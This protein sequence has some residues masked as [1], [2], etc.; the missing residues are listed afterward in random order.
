[1]E[2]D[3]LFGEYPDSNDPN[4]TCL[5]SADY[6]FYEL[7]E[8][9]QPE[10]PISSKKQWYNR[11]LL[12]QRM[13]L[14]QDVSLNISE[15]GTGK[16]GCFI[17]LSEYIKDNVPQFKQCIVLSP[18]T[19]GKQF[20]NDL[21]F[22]YTNGRYI[23][24]AIR[25]AKDKGGRNTAITSSI[26]KFYTKFTTFDDFCRKSYEKY[27]DNVASL[28]TK[29]SDTLFCC[30]EIHLFKVDNQSPFES[31]RVQNY[32]QL[33][34][35]FHVIQRSKV[36]YFTATP[37]TRVTNEYNY[38][39]NLMY[40]LDNQ[41]DTPL[42]RKIVAQTGLD[43]D[44][45]EE[46]NWGY[47]SG[48]DY[49]AYFYEHLRGKVFFAASSYDTAPYSYHVVLT[50]EP[51]VPLAVQQFFR[52]IQDASTSHVDY[53]AIDRTRR[54]NML[55]GG[56]QQITYSR[57]VGTQTFEELGIAD[58]EG[59]T[60]DG[61]QTVARSLSSFVFPDGSHGSA[62]TNAWT[63]EQNGHRIVNNAVTWPDSNG[64]AQNL[65]WWIYNHLAA[66]SCKFYYVI[67][68]ALFLSGKS[69]VAI[70]NVNAGGAAI[71][72]LTLETF[73]FVRYDHGSAPDKRLRYSV[74]EGKTGSKTTDIFSIFN[75]PDN[76]HG[77]YIKV[78]IMSRVAQTGISLLED[79]R[80]IVADIPWAP[81]QLY[82]T[83]KRA[84]RVGAHKY[85]Q[86]E[87]P[88]FTVE[89]SIL[90][91]ET[92]YSPSVDLNIYLRGDDT[93]RVLAEPLRGLKQI[94]VDCLLE[95]ARNNLPASLNGYPEADYGAASY[96]CYYC[97]EVQALNYKTYNT[98]YHNEVLQ[99]YQHA[100]IDTF[101]AN[102]VQTVDTIADL[103]P[104][105][106]QKIYVEQVLLDLVTRGAV[107]EDA[108]GLPSVLIMTRPGVFQLTRLTS[109]RQSHDLILT[110]SS[111]PIYTVQYD[112]DITDIIIAN[113]FLHVYDNFV[114]VVPADYSRKID[115]LNAFA[116]IALLERVV[117]DNIEWYMTVARLF[118]RSK[119]QGLDWVSEFE[120]FRAQHGGPGLDGLLMVVFNYF[121][122]TN[123]F[124][125]QK[126]VTTIGKGKGEIS[127]SPVEGTRVFIHNLYSTVKASKGAGRART[128][129]Q[130]NFKKRIID[131]LTVPA[132]W[133]TPTDA[134]DK[135]Y[136]T[137]F[138]DKLNSEQAYFAATF[139]RFYAK[140]IQEDDYHIV[141]LEFQSSAD[142][143]GRDKRQGKKSGNYDI[144]ELLY[145][146]FV[147]GIDFGTPEVYDGVDQRQFMATAKRVG[148][149]VSGA[150]EPHWVFQAGHVNSVS[151]TFVNY[152]YRFFQ[153][154]K[155]I[156]N[157]RTEVI[158][159][160]LL[161][162]FIQTGRIFQ[163]TF[164][165]IALYVQ[166]YNKYQG[167]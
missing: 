138:S 88:N 162:E 31:D 47:Q 116:R 142:A 18:G 110:G 20:R 146:A 114:D 163:T 70:E 79:A 66:L 43:V 137:Y 56:I 115:T 13:M 23:N 17:C 89:I 38:L 46:P 42:M 61:F 39:L 90:I 126:I 130:A 139:P 69:Y 44:W 68:T 8:T 19:P 35:V 155:G 76:Y 123:L 159:L 118:E 149:F 48:F 95:K 4:I 58:V 92:K 91:A 1:M 3:V 150:G 133:Y 107:L 160:L 32:T 166:K 22:K 81:G 54:V 97:N 62:G 37:V 25:N 28:I 96:D 161:R 136:S 117:Q 113:N 21:V 112:Y 51:N 106:P 124:I 153:A 121:Y 57:H 65:T 144:A 151:D 105:I 145:F 64:Q 55:I 73:G 152:C 49:A 86:A 59:V 78:I 63:L 98:Y 11:Q 75:H 60:E 154:Y 102:S 16:T 134:E 2:L 33:W 53:H 83:V 29:Y 148:L 9:E 158:T 135:G 104:S 74:I 34:F 164:N 15:A 30:D 52:E 7:R 119:Q 132:L 156:G 128:F 14:D 84:L 103:L 80:V 94:A 77:D 24:A 71:L 167:L 72:A 5:L 120:A 6:E 100:I 127:V 143:N 131:P 10:A 27:K 36:C 93:G 157:G 165:A 40:P 85:N 12:Y 87:N 122:D 129:N 140:I 125:T 41:I 109:R 101:R 141:A 82:Q 108:F 147:L 67:L 111:T 45:H 50:Y 99:T 26:R